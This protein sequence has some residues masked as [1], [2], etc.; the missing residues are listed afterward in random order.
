MINPFPNC[1]RGKKD[2]ED[3]KKSDVVMKYNEKHEAIFD[4]LREKMGY[5]PNVTSE[6]YNGIGSLAIYV[7]LTSIALIGFPSFL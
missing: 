5:G 4:D 1:P 6:V 2:Y 7:S 3:Y